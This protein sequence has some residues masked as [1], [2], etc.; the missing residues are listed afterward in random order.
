MQYL[1]V[2][3]PLLKAGMFVLIC[4][5]AFIGSAKAGLDY[6]KIFLGKKLI[7]ERF[8]DK[9][10]SLQSLP[11]S[12]A[13]ANETL[14]IY[15]FQCNAP[16]RT[17]NNRVI[18]LKDDNGNIIKQWTFANA[19]G[20][21][22]GMAIPVKELLQLQKVNKSSLL[23]LYYKAEGRSGGEKLASI[24]AVRKDVASIHPQNDEDTSQIAWLVIN[25]LFKNI[26]IV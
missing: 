5:T 2:K 10:L 14:N 13:N 17:G 21:K 4:L 11:I 15:Y 25:Y 1:H 24:P 16:G 6:Y 23:S 12:A 26:G 7:Y 8:L 9:P 18:A 19:Q 3:K 22:T 20:D